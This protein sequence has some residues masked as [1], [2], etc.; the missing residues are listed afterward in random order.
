[1]ASDV[2]VEVPEIARRGMVVLGF[3]FPALKRQS[4]LIGER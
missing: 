3:G 4:A 1:L 2:D